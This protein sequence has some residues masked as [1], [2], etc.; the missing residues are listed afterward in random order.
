M[1][2]YVKVQGSSSNLKKVP[3]PCMKI[4]SPFTEMPSRKA[5]LRKCRHHRHTVEEKNTVTSS[6]EMPSI[7]LKNTVTKNT[8]TAFL[9]IPSRSHTPAGKKIPSHPKKYRHSIP[10]RKQKLQKY[11]QVTAFFFYRQKNDSIFYTTA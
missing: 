10:S 4:P 2:A 6:A 1:A 8:V 11:R 7:S 5:F 9:R 3:S